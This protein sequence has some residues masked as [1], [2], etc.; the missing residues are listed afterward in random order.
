MLTFL[1][2]T[3]YGQDDEMLLMCYGCAFLL[4]VEWKSSKDSHI[5]R[6]S[7]VGGPVS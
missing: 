3:P 6:R 7:K 2:F 5:Q 4:F 1:N